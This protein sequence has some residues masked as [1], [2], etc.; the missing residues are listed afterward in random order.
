MTPF[1]LQWRILLSVSDDYENFEHIKQFVEGEARESLRVVDCR[2]A[3]RA[4]LDQKL[5]CAFRYNHQTFQYEMLA[6]QAIADDAWFY[7]SSDGA[8]VIDLVRLP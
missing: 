4:L 5:V 7:V 3:L 6:S 1:E 8:R 2:S